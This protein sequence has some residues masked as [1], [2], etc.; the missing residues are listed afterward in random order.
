MLQGILDP[1][2]ELA[3]LEK[4]AAEVTGRIE[5]LRKKMSLPGYAD[6]TPAP[7]QAEDSDKLGRNEAELA[8]AQQHMQ[9]MRSMIAEQQQQ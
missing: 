8:A 9:D 3:K 6:K 5:A 7:V 4:K 2:L 1:T